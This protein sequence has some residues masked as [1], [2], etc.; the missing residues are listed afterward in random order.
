ME[1]EFN[2]NIKQERFAPRILF[3]GANSGCGKTTITSGIMA[4][5]KRRGRKVQA[6][7]CGPD[8]IDP[9]FH[10]FITGRPSINLDSWLM[11][12]ETV[13]WLFQ[14]HSEAGDVSLI[15]GMMGIFDGYDGK[16]LLASSA[17]IGKITD[18][19]VILIVNCEGMALSIAALIQGFVHFDSE[20]KIKGVILNNVHGSS[21][22]SF[23][24]EVIEANTKVLVLGYLNKLPE[25]ILPSRHLGLVT[26]QEIF[27]LQQKMDILTEEIEKTVDL[28]QLMEIAERAA[29]LQPT[30]LKLQIHRDGRGEKVRIAVAYDK[31]FNFYYQDNLDLL[32]AWGSELVFFSPISDT[33]LPDNIHGIYLGGGYPEVWARELS[34]NHSMKVELKEMAESEMPIYGECGGLMYLCRSIQTLEGEIFH[35]T[36][37]LPG[38]SKMTRNLQRFGYV[39]IT[40]R[41][42]KDILGKEVTIRGHEFHFSETEMTKPIHTSYRVTRGSGEY[43]K[44]WD[45]GYVWKNV[46]GAYAHLHFYSNP[47]FA[48]KFIDKCIRYKKMYGGNPR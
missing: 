39:Q 26:S 12:E 24:K 14:K 30:Q 21:H 18:A 5:L 10:T 43:E 13:A 15:E 42:D 46:L 16:T 31:A 1:M 40:T 34:E 29:P 9:M 22:Y 7:K 35:M 45:C 11:D 19:P 8:Y 27:E 6:F 17:H 25:I 32:R 3:A 36:D 38:I 23:L 28:K 20:V 33:K 2:K 37:I 41:K 4:A 47:L 48:A 44:S